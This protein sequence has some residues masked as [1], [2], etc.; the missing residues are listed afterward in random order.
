MQ[1]LANILDYPIWLI[2]Q[3][4]IYGLLIY[5]LIQILIQFEIIPRHNQPARQAQALLHRIY[6]LLMAPIRRYVPIVAV[7]L[8]PL[9]TM[10]LIMAVRS[11]LIWLF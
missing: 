9:V 1:L 10:I 11:I 7:R 4:A 8:V 3:I 2:A 5:I 6:D